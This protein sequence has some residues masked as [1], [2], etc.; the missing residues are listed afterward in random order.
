[1]NIY[2]WVGYV[3]TGVWLV[4]LIAAFVVAMRGV[5]L[6]ARSEED[7]DRLVGGRVAG[8]LAGAAILVVLPI[9]A[10]FVL[11]GRTT[12]A[13]G[14]TALFSS[15]QTVIL[16]VIVPLIAV[17]ISR[18]FRPVLAGFLLVYAF[19]TVL[20]A[21]SALYWAYGTEKNFGIPLSH[22][23]AFYF[24]LG[25]LTT[26]GTGNIAAK[27]ETGRAIQT[28]QL[29][30]DLV[31]IGFIIALVVARYSALFNSAQRVLQPGGSPA[32]TLSASGDSSAQSPDAS[33][34]NNLHAGHPLDD[35]GGPEETT[36]P[37]PPPDIP[38][39]PGEAIE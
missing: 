28:V 12:R 22:L 3:M 8:Y 36:D 38:R 30:F 14:W 18:R 34:P 26:A 19:A 16:L 5:V 31:F 15:L 37:E 13:P 27:S 21:F 10:W 2:T 1:M 20:E 39:G 4:L 17:S 35:H 33:E 24:A 29:G 25:T 32:G 11:V 7:E 9:A 6:W 23:D